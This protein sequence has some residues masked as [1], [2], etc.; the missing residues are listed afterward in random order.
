MSKKR[1]LKQQTELEHSIL[2]ALG[3]KSGSERLEV[4]LD[5]DLSQ[6]HSPQNVNPVCV[7]QMGRCG[8]SFLSVGEQT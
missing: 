3:S 4:I 6:E 2:M 5:A 1:K 8:S 7:S